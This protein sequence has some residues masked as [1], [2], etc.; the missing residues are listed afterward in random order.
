[1]FWNS[2]QEKSVPPSVP[3]LP[4]QVTTVPPP[5]VEVL[6][7]KESTLPLS[8]ETSEPHLG[9][10]EPTTIQQ[11]PWDDEPQS[12]QSITKAEAWV[13]PEVKQKQE[14]PP[15]EP[16]EPPSAAER[17]EPVLS[18]LPAQIQQQ[19]SSRSSTPSAGGKRPLSAAHRNS[20]KFKVTDQAV[21][22]PNSS[23]TPAAEKLGMQF[24]SLGLGGDDF[25]S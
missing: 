9:W 5:P 19:E 11:P 2:P 4:P 7:G 20:A 10:E 13:P 24:G 23:F 8:E 12:K 22:M 6:A 14:F 15:V 3:I 25:D 16:S 17:H 21:V 1:V 18:A